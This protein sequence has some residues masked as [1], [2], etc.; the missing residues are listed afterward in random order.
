MNYDLKRSTENVKNKVKGM[1][2]VKM[3]LLAVMAVGTI[4]SFV[5]HDRI[6]PA[7]SV[8]NRGISASE[9]INGLLAVVP[10]IIQVVRVVTVILVVTTVALFI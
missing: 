9:F 8:F 4:C 2:A 6:F 10:K 3:I 7:D 1:G 5:F